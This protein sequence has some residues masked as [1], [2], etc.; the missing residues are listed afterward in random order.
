MHCIVFAFGAQHCEIVFLCVRRQANDVPL[1]IM[2]VISSVRLKLHAIIST[3]NLV[4]AVRRCVDARAM[5]FV[6]CAIG[7]WLQQ[8]YFNIQ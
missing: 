3:C 2:I 4:A 7:K 8:S 5:I 1:I 6:N